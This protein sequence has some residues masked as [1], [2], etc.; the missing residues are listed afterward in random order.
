MDSAAVAPEPQRKAMKS[1]F[2]TVQSI[3][4]R[5]TKL[6]KEVTPLTYVL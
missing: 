3:Y 4:I 5:L 6:D 1:A 2:A